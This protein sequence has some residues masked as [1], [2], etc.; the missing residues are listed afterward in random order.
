MATYGYHPSG[1]AQ[2]AAEGGD[3]V[4]NYLAY[5]PDPMT[6][7]GWAY[8]MGVAIGPDHSGETLTVALSIHD[9]NPNPGGIRQTSGTFTPNVV[10]VNAAGTSGA[11]YTAA[12]PAEVMMHNGIAY[13][14]SSAA[15]GCT[16]VIGMIAADAY[17]GR[18]N[19]LFYTGSDSSLPPADPHNYYKTSFEGHF[20][21][22][23]NFEPNVP[24][25]KPVTLSPVNGSTPS[26]L[27]PTFS[28][29]FSDD[30][31]TLPGGIDADELSTFKIE[32][33]RVSDGALM[34]S[35]DDDSVS[36]ERSARAFSRVYDGTALASGVQYRWRCLVRDRFGSASVYSDWQYFTPG[37]SSVSVAAGSPSGKQETQTPG[38]FTGVWTH[39]GGLSTNAVR[40]RIKNRVSGAIVRQLGSSG[41]GTIAKTV[42]PGGTISITWGETAFAAL[43]WGGDYVYEIQGRDT[44]NNWSGWSSPTRAFTVNAAPSTPTN[45]APNETVPPKTSYPLLTATVSDLDDTPATGLIVKAGI[46]GP[47][48]IANKDF[49]TDATGWA[50]VATAGFTVTLSHDPATGSPANGSAKAE[51][52]AN[53]A[54]IGQNV[55]VRGNDHIPCVPGYPYTVRAALRTDN[56]NITPRLVISW[57]TSADA[58]IVTLV[59]NDWTPVANAWSDH[60]LVGSP[61]SNAAYF[62]IGWEL[63]CDTANPLG[64]TWADHVSVDD[65]V[66]YLRSMTFDGS[67]NRWQYQT[68]GTDIQDE[69]VYTF[70]TYAFDGTTYSG[71]T[72]VEAS[73]AKSSS[74]SFAYALGPDV[75]ITTPIEGEVL[76]TDTPTIAWTSSSTQAARRVIVRDATTHETLPDGDTGIVVTISQTYDLPAG[77]IEDDHSYEVMVQVTDTLAAVGSSDWRTFSLDYIEPPSVPGFLGS[78]TYAPGDV[79]PSAVRLA[80][81]QVDITSGEFEFYKVSTEPAEDVPYTL[82]EKEQKSRRRRI[83][84][85]PNQSITTFTDYTPP[86]GVPLRYRIRQY[87]RKGSALVSSQLSTSQVQVDFHQGILQ[88]F[89]DGGH[90]TQ[91]EHRVVLEY[92]GDV[93]VR[94]NRDAVT[95]QRMGKRAPLVFK[96]Q[97]YWRGISGRFRLHGDSVADVEAQ[98]RELEFLDGLNVPCLWRDGRGRRMFCFVDDF[99]EADHSGGRVRDVDLVLT[100]IDV[101]EIYE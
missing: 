55:K 83:G 37:A 89:G 30:N 50:V 80:W 38:P 42:A 36:A 31:E 62:R 93:T 4:N 90:G 13:A 7:D 48:V 99:N 67:L 92:R 88:S 86:S 65:G 56:V 24:P 57:Y 85:L 1:A 66:R 47:M 101:P 97:A 44:A 78:P 22:W 77:M 41:T 74:A 61:P 70:W 26:S 33:R 53:T 73:A 76:D 49:A 64:S 15:Y 29:N 25:D 96:G 35:L 8:S 82:E 87:V 21:I 91:P 28:G 3:N 54:G 69:G 10:V 43:P 18:D 17:P 20:A 39:T 19:Y 5:V 81:Q 45:L 27:T 58:L 51:I 68:T 95:W 40:V 32:V 16:H 52:T 72:T 12:L 71:G 59:E 23:V 6:Q 100:Q 60:L 75:T 98:L 84:I 2:N 34:W 14:L 94:R 79:E 63:Y 46:V 11:K 9:A